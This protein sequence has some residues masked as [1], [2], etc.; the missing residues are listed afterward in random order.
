M[1]FL[2]VISLSGLATAA[3][4]G[5]E[6]QSVRRYGAATKILRG[7]RVQMLSKSADAQT[8]IMSPL[9]ISG[10]WR[11]YFDFLCNY[12]LIQCTE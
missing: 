1:F 4:G 2:I 7:R 10:L 9:M 8:L 3:D 5:R 12:E 6:V 11:L